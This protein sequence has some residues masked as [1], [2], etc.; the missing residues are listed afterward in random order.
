MKKQTSTLLLFTK[1]IFFSTL[2]LLTSC[3]SLKPEEQLVVNWQKALEEHDYKTMYIGLSLQAR[4]EI[5]EEAFI[6][7]QDQVNV[8]EPVRSAENG[9]VMEY[10][11]ISNKETTTGV[12]EILFQSITK[13]KE[14]KETIDKFS[15]T[16]FTVKCEENSCLLDYKEENKRVRERWQNIYSAVNE[17]DKT[18]SLGNSVVAGDLDVEITWPQNI[19]PVDFL[20]PNSL[21]GTTAQMIGSGKYPLLLFVDITNKGKDD[22]FVS[23]SDFNLYN[24]KKY[25]MESY[26]RYVVKDKQLS[27]VSLASGKKASGYLMFLPDSSLPLW[28]GEGVVNKSDFPVVLTFKQNSIYL[29]EKQGQNFVGGKSSVTFSWN[30]PNPHGNNAQE[31]TPLGK[32]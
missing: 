10:K 9:W 28:T 1:A 29:V 31:P 24:N 3:S 25:V 17:K 22:I 21:I 8:N 2:L 5:S 16:P 23:P 27:S 14:S 12:H 7:W 15:P 18:F 13:L 6:Y 19:A 30:I 20:T 11:I 32:I 4:S 26:S